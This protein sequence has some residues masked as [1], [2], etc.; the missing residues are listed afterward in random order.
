MNLPSVDQSQEA[1][2]DQVMAHVEGYEK[3]VNDVT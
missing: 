1:I 2:N 3:K